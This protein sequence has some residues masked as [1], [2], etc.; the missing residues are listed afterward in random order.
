MKINLAYI[1]L[2]ILFTLEASTLSG[3]ESFKHTE[4]KTKI[5][6]Y[7]NNSVSNGYSGSVLVAKNGEIILSK[8]YGWSDR[9]RK[10]NNTSSTV[11]NI[12]SVTKQFTAAAILKLIEQ[13]K[14]KTSDNIGQFFKKAPLDKKEITIHQLLTH[15]SG[16]SPKTGG[17]R[18][19]EAS[20]EHFINT[21]FEASL[22]SKPGTKHKYANANYIMLSAI[23]ELV[24]EQDYTTFLNDNFWKPLKMFHTGYKSISFNSEQLAHGY[25]FNYSDG[26]WKDWGT[27]QEHLPYTDNHWYSIGKGDIHSTVEDLYKWHVALNIG[28]ILNAKSK[29]LFE[30]PYVAEDVAGTSHYGY[31]WAIFRSKQNTKT[32]THNGSNGIYFAN[33]IRYIDDDV[34]VIELSNAILGKETESVAWRISDIVFDEN[35]IP[36]PISKSVY[37]LVYDFMKT[38]EVENVKLISS[39]L[40]KNIG[41]KFNDRAV[42]NRIGNKLLEKENNPGWGLELLK[43]NVE[44]F[45]N[46]GNLFDSLGDAYF[47]Y[48]QRENTI[49]AFT[50]A[51]ELKPIDNCHW[52][53]NSNNKLN[54][55]KNH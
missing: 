12:G 8:G 2:V 49:Q 24:S 40:E 31:G 32:V 47:K 9:I 35:Y 27:T 50:R 17:Y 1:I 33:F 45:S 5:N 14:I 30:T 25:Y 7:L 28:Q 10:I 4:L 37:E 43:L 29:V 46:D 36:K 41:Q 51:L 54:L 16:I 13:E 6:T 44:I 48:N 42:F 21:F 18:Y 52:C 23:I 22:Q 19:D 39:F 15:T 34:V 20:K 3:Q 26:I 11:F 38:N 53:K 55:L